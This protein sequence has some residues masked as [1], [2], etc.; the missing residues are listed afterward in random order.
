MPEFACGNVRSR[1]ARID[2]QFWLKQNH[3]QP[4]DMMPLD[5]LRA[6]ALELLTQVDSIVPQYDP[7]A[8]AACSLECFAELVVH[9]D[10]SGFAIIGL[11][12]D[13]GLRPEHI[14]RPALSAHDLVRSPVVQIGV[15]PG[16]AHDQPGEV[17]GD[18][19]NADERPFVAALPAP[20]D[21]LADPSSR[22]QP[23]TRQ[24]KETG[25]MG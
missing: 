17:P 19:R 1:K 24:Q 8:L 13:G 21:Q 5:N 18:Q 20:G 4:T 15:R 9:K 11:I 23:E 12:Q 22:E 25:S 6:G 14:T 16:E 3:V 10:R 2:G 7:E